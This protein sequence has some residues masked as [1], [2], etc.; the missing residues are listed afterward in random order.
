MTEISTKFRNSLKV[1]LLYQALLRESLA[2]IS[3]VTITGEKSHNLDHL[4]MSKNR[5]G[6]LRAESEPCSIPYLKVGM[7]YTNQTKR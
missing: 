2:K 3:E 5:R 6:T 7:M 4:V 1:A